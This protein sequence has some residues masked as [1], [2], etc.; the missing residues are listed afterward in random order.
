[1]DEFIDK[2]ELIIQINIEP[3]TFLFLYIKTIEEG[4]NILF[5]A[6]KI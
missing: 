6:I 4:P 2:G 3:H 5:D 1:M